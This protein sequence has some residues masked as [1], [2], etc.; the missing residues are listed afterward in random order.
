LALKQ[1]TDRWAHRWAEHFVRNHILVLI[2]FTVY[3]WL[4]WYLWTNY[5]LI[6]KGTPLGSLISVLLAVY[7]LFGWSIPLRYVEEYPQQLLKAER[8]LLP[9]FVLTFVVYTI[10]ILFAGQST[11]LFDLAAGFGWAWIISFWT[12]MMIFRAYHP[13]S[14]A[15]LHAFKQTVTEGPRASPNELVKRELRLLAGALSLYNRYL[16]STYGLKIREVNRF[17][18]PIVIESLA[19]TQ[20]AAIPIHKIDDFI[21]S[22]KQGPLVFLKSARTM[23]GQPADKL[24]NLYEDIEIVPGS[25]QTISKYL[26]PLVT[27]IVSIVGVALTAYKIFAR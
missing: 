4:L 8:L 22:I 2:G 20:P 13:R 17:C 1:L 6:V 24:E 21:L 23:I 16:V 19:Q 5:R 25:V 14:L 18:K 26:I 27:I 12:Y 7:C 9:L 10:G 3:N 15:R 11:F